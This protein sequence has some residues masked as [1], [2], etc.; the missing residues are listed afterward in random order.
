MLTWFELPGELRSQILE[1]YFAGAVVSYGTQ[2]PSDL[3]IVQIE[4]VLQGVFD[5][6]LVAKQFVT[7]S[8]II[9]AVIKASTIKITHDLNIRKLGTVLDHGARRI[10]KIVKFSMYHAEGKSPFRHWTLDYLQEHLGSIRSVVVVGRDSSL[11]VGSKPRLEQVLSN[12]QVDIGERF[13][14]NSLQRVE[15]ETILLRTCTNSIDYRIEFYQ[16]GKLV[17]DIMAQGIELE[18]SFCI[19][20]RLGRFKASF[21][22]RDWCVRLQE[23]YLDVALPQTVSMKCLELDI[24]DPMCL[25]DIK[26]VVR[27]K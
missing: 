6:K 16:S 17:R 7:E 11:D 22:T 10:P 14:I 19:R 9:L 2:A 3:K 15:I 12:P 21:S 8:E 5:I 20:C 18:M 27:E 23:K 26:E 13:V 4:P 25:P 1:H 24:A